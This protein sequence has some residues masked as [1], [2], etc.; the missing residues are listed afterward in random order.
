M[1]YYLAHL[2]TCCASLI[3]ITI[4]ILICSSVVVPLVVLVV[5]LIIHLFFMFSKGVYI[6]FVY[7]FFFFFFFFFVRL[8]TNIF[9][10]LT[11]FLCFW[12]ISRYEIYTDILLTSPLNT[13]VLLTFFFLTTR[14]HFLTCLTSGLCLFLLFYFLIFFP[15]FLF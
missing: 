10:I 6:P 12:K 8:L 4:T 7:F 9:W 14:P 5:L 1:Q 13:F 15:S 11:D 3:I 2:C